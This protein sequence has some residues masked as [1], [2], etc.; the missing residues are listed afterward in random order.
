MNIPFVTKAP[1]TVDGIL[2]SFTTMVDGLKTVIVR[3]QEVAAAAEAEANAA[4]DR[5]AAAK[6]EASRAAN[7]ITKIEKL[8]A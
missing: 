4:R 8:L 6:T 2:S 7:A 3:E 5:A 1:L